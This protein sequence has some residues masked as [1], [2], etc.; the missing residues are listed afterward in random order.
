MMDEA[1]YQAKLG[2]TPASAG[3]YYHLNRQGKIIYVG[4]AVNL[5]RRLQAYAP[6]KSGLT[7]K[8]ERLRAQIADFR[9]STTDNGF[10]ALLLEG[11][12]ISRHRPKFNV[13]DRNQLDPSW[14]YVNFSYQLHNPHLRLT[15]Q[16]Q[17][18]QAGDHLGPYLQAQPL[19]KIL[20]Y[21]RR[22]FPYATHARRPAKPC[23]E[24]HLGLCLCPAA[25]DFKPQQAVANLRRLK[26][27]LAGR[28]ASLRR[29]LGSA[30]RQA[31]ASQ[32]YEQAAAARDQLQALDDFRQSLIFQELPALSPAADQALVE[33]Q[34]LLNLAQPPQ[35]VEAYDISHLGGRHVAA[36]M[37][38]AQ[39][40]II[41]P[42]FKRRFKAT[43]ELNND[44]AQIEQILR[45]RLSSKRLEQLP[46]LIVI[47]GGRGQVGAV[48]KALQAL[49]LQVPVIGLAKRQ[50]E[51]ICHKTSFQINQAEL[52]RLG[53]RQLQSPNFYQLQI[54]RQTDLI[55]FLQ[56]LRDASHRFALS[57]QQQLHSRSQLRSPLLDLP[58]IGPVTYKRLMAKFGAIT[59]WRRL[60]LADFQA[61]VSARQAQTLYAYFHPLKATE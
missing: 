9:Y 20:K 8:D 36:S 5:R 52:Q 23:L 35:R 56:R 37:I 25:S 27:Y 46:D 30:M 31:A 24:A 3:V 51:I 33:L 54:P 55:K 28:H 10:Q 2:R 48:L 17:P 44:V 34:K 6:S 41:V 32:A 19:R 45:R 40:G 53:G 38:V 58:G 12:M 61:V 18:P 11:E 60:S 4:K 57:Y 1:A 47:D 59:D 21:L 29:Q 42:H 26:L 7:L 50:E 22:H 15:R 39:S 43:A 13:V 49:Q 14:V 16:P